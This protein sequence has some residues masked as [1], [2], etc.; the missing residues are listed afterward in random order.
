M[1]YTESNLIKLESDIE[2]M[3][4]D[5]KDRIL[6][7]NPRTISKYLNKSSSYLYDV[8]TGQKIIS[9]KS[10]IEMLKKIFEW[11]RENDKN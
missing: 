3:R 1:A 11:E 8:A 6:K 2:K 9:V 10:S 7:L 5:L 4:S